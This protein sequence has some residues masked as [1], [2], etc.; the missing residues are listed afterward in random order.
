MMEKLEGYHSRIKRLS[1]LVAQLERGELSLDDLSEMETI[2][3]ELHERSIILRYNAFK[4]KVMPGADEGVEVEVIIEEIEPEEELEPEEE[5][6]IDFSIFDDEQEGEEEP[7][8]I[9]EIVGNNSGT[10]SGGRA[11]TKGRGIDRVK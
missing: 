7:A 3:R 10:K 1:E 6:A 4:D 8:P 11:R 9:P 5:Q 2:T